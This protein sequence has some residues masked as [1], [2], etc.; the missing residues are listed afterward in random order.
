MR[1]EINEPFISTLKWLTIKFSFDFFKQWTLLQ[2]ILVLS[3]ERVAILQIDEKS[4]LMT[5]MK[6]EA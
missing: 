1:T 3:A 5:G 2:S 4:S 6:C